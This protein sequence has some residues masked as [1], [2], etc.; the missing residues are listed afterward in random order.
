MNNFTFDETKKDYIQI[1]EKERPYWVTI[2]RDVVDVPNKIGGRLKSTKFEALNIKVK[3]R[4]EAESREQLQERIENM[5]SWLIRDESKKL[6]F[7]DMPDRAYYALLDGDV[8]PDKELV[9][10]SIFELNFVCPDPYK[11][12]REKQAVRIKKL[13][14][15]DYWEDTWKEVKTQDEY[16]D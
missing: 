10:F 12:G 4:V 2:D 11:Y 7:D 3:V 1:V 15:E 5:A 14:W 13:T 9:T 16:Q 8:V 6:V